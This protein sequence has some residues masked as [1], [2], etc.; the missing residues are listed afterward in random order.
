M[1]RIT[2]L[3]ALL[4]AMALGTASAWAATP[5]VGQGNTAAVTA[6]NKTVT[7]GTGHVPVTDGGGKGA[8][9]QAINHNT[10]AV[11]AGNESEANAHGGNANASNNAQV[12]QDNSSSGSGDSSSWDGCKRG[13]PKSHGS[14]TDQE[15]ESTVNQG[16][17]NATGGDATATGGNGGNANTGN[18]QIYN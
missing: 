10:V 13:C 17:N 6:G 11:A 5:E 18:T 8:S 9:Q 1:K 15:N 12:Q 4:V 14:E 3:M 7:V 16:D 2:G